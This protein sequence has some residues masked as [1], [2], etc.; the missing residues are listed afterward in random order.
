MSNY[1]TNLISNH[2]DAL[3]VKY[4]CIGDAHFIY[5]GLKD[6]VRRVK[7][8]KKFEALAFME[9]LSCYRRLKTE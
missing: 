4:D 8:D 9:K 2:S 3:D 1:P 5:L 7:F 6:Q